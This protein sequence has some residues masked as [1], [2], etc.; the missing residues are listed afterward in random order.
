[1]QLLVNEVTSVALD[2]A[3]AECCNSRAY[4]DV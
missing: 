4:S 2:T 1:M 3:G